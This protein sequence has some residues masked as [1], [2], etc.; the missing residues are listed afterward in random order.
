MSYEVIKKENSEVTVKVTVSAEDFDKAVQT[1]YNKN[2]G[3][4]NIPGFRKGKAPKG[5]I[6]RQYG[7]GV[8]F[9]DAINALLP[10]H[11]GNAIDALSL[12]PVAKPD[13]DIEE[14]EAHKAFVFTAVVTVKPEFELEGY[15]GVEAEKIDADVTEDMIEA[16]LKK[17]QDMNARL[18]SVTGRPVQEGDTVF[19][20]YQGF[21]G[22]D[23]FEGG[24]ADD[25]ELVIG[26]GQFIPGFE[27]QLIGA[28]IGA[29]VDVKV[30][31]PEQYHSEDLAGKDAVFHVTINSIK[32]K[33]LPELDDEFA[34]DVSEFDTLED[35]KQSIREEL[36]TSAQS[37]AEAAQ[38]DKVLEA[39]AALIPIEI[40][41]KMVEAEIDGMLDEYD[42][43]L[44]YQGLSLEQ[45]AQYM[46]GSLDG[47]RDQV[48]EDA[49]ARVKTGLVIEKV[50]EK[51][52]IEATEADVEEE[53]SKIAEAQ[54]RDLD[55]V[56][57]LFERDDFE[58]LK[59]NLKSR[60]TVDFLVEHAQL[61]EK[62]VSDTDAG[63]A[64]AADK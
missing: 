7:E 41:E 34:K 39:A 2:K 1:A 35:Y 24:T 44:R 12:E 10:E 17:T 25:Q 26:S 30:T 54:K 43:Q 28:E 9:E 40:P 29:H 58:Y 32:Y 36:E 27:E 3:R 45:Y 50:M 59:S 56:R 47:L 38:R 8:F 19:I 55:E 57:K 64:A 22:D 42:Q 60:K 62:R 23:Q 61:V 14:V 5:I 51:E 6:E 15:K 52:G 11:Y 48:R 21:V 63:E 31:F 49:L 33:E 13:I 16:E 4:F 53:L 18:V 20:D 46:G 37:S